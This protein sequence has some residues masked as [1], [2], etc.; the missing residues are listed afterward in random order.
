MKL[1]KVVVYRADDWECL[2]VNGRSEYQGHSIIMSHLKTQC[3]IKSIEIRWVG[4]NLDAHVLE[5]GGFPDTLEEC[6]EI[7]KKDKLE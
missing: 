3:P 4:E 1:N 7:E 5:G 2:Y 6:L